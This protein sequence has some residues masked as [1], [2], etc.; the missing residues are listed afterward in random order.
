MLADPTGRKWYDMI[1]SGKGAEAAFEIIVAFS[2]G[3]FPKKLHVSAGHRRR[4]AAP[5]AKRSRQR[6]MRTTPAGLRAFI[7]FEWT[8]NTGGNNLHRNVIFRENGERARLVEPFTCLS[9]ARQR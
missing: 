3:T 1:Q 5:G 2:Q 8:S 6:T 9:A 4:I 7:G